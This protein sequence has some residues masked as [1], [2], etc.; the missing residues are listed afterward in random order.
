VWVFRHEAVPHTDFIHPIPI[1]PK[2][3]TP[4]PDTWDNYLAFQTVRCFL[5][6]GALLSLVPQRAAWSNISN[7]FVPYCLS[8]LL[9]DVSGQWA[10]MIYSNF[11]DPKEVVLGQKCEV[12]VI[13][14]GIAHM[15]ENE[16]VKAWLE[17]WKCIDD[18]K[19]KD[20]YEFYNVLWIERK[21]EIAYRKALGRVWKDVWQRQPV[22]EID[23]ILG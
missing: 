18:I 23:V 12:I 2:P 19:D 3:L 4:N 6:S 10:G 15:D 20:T 17:E 11:S 1:P 7:D 9:I 16:S 13:S 5:Y 14:A 8:F 21:G 22:E